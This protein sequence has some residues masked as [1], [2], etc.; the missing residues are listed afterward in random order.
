MSGVFITDGAGP[1]GKTLVSFFEKEGCKVA[2]HPSNGNTESIR[3]AIA[4][5]GPIGLLIN[6]SEPEFERL[7]F[8]QINE[9]EFSAMVSAIIRTAFFAVQAVQPVMRILG[10][11][12]IINISS[13]APVRGMLK[14][15]HYTAAKGALYS[16]TRSWA[17]ELSPDNIR[18]NLVAAD[19]GLGTAAEDG[20]GE[21]PFGRPV[22][23]QDIIRC[24]EFL[25]G[26]GGNMIS[27]QEIIVDGGF[28]KF[29]F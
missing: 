23:F 28:T 1:L 10:G 18:V 20:G 13:S 24:V 11:G 19:V 2:T 21:T 15:A 7:S 29:G 6:N 26:S 8:E 22:S 9:R 4:A 25:A 5:A 3:E 27:G 12:K 14:G 16:L 17:Q